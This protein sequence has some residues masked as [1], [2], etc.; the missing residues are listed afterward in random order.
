MDLKDLIAVKTLVQM[1]DHDNENQ[2]G[3]GL[4]DEENSVIQISTSRPVW[5][6]IPV[7]YSTVMHVL[8]KQRLRKKNFHLSI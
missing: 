7:R 4:D 1:A 8:L 5:R 3:S 2:L 6:H